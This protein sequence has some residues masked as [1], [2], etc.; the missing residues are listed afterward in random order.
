MILPM[1]F[2]LSGFL[3]TGSL[4]RTRTLTEFIALRLLRLVPALAVEVTL[5]A[6]VL[7]ALFTSL[8]IGQYF[9]DPAFWKYFLNIAGRIHYS[10][11]GVFQDNPIPIVNISLWTIPYELEWYLISAPCHSGL[12]ATE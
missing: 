5:S 3:V 7:G 12:W 1:F 8:P 11:P 2:A 9:S 6:V 10:L 4:F